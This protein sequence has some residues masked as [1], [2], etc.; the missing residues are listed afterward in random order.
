VLVCRIEHGLKGAQVQE[1][2]ELLHP[3]ANPNHIRAGIASAPFRPPFAVMNEEED[4]GPVFSLTGTVKWYKPDKGFGF[5]T[6]D[7]GQKDIFIHQSCL[8][9]H[10]MLDLPAGLRLS[11]K[12]RAVPKGRE[13]LDFE[14]IEG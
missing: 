11:M 14:I 8:R 4:T 13:V 1:V 9:Q 10:D 3:G 2:V 7:D 12:V 5:V 6:P